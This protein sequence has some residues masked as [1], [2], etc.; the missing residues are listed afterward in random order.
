MLII[1]IPGYEIIKVK[2]VVFDFNGTLAV[3]D[4]LVDGVA[5]KIVE[6]IK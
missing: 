5:E 2:N 4:I 1:D 6:L 3:D